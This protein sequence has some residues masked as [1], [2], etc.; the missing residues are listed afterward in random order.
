MQ[1]SRRSNP[2]NGPGSP[3]KIEVVEVRGGPC[4]V[5]YQPGRMFTVCGPLVP[6]D[7]CSWAWN[8]LLPSVAV[9]R[10]GGTLPWEDE[11]GIARTSCP[12]PDNIVVFRLSS[13]RR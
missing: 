6:E 10:F 3:V 2:D 4:P 11:P 7:M 1:G 8:A 13:E 9:L 12:D 5:G